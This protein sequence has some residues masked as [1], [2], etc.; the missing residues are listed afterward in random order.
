MG[1]WIN[2]WRYEMASEP[3][4]P[5]VWRLRQ[6]GWYVRAR[7]TNP[8]TGKQTQIFRVLDDGDADSAYAWLRGEVQR[9]RAG[10]TQTPTSRA[11][12]AE[13]AKS[14]LEKKV[15]H[16]RIWSPKGREKWGYVLEHH[17]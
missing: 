8:K 14:V 2:R 15:A 12:F 17:L 6:G 9:V 16:G 3:S 5:G 10:G 7:V 4:R 11:R 13:Y 1:K